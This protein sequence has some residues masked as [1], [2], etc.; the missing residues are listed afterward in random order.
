MGRLY[1]GEFA[2][3]GYM[4]N[5]SDLPENREQLEK[6]LAG[7]HVNILE[8]GI[9]VSRKSDLIFY[10][11]PIEDIEKAVAYCGPSTKKDA[12]VSSGTSV[13]AP[14]VKAFERYLPSDVNII[15]WHWLFGSSIRPQG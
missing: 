13:M 15:N 3:A 5:C 10:L 6:D 8:D 9:A 12:I 11:V 1:A 2:K 7:T 4:V 14:A